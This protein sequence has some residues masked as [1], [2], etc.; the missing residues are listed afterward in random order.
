VWAVTYSL[1]GYVFGQYW[2][3]LLAVAKSIGYGIIAI[4]ALV[5]LAYVLRRRWSRNS[6]Q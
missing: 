4:V 6:P 2:D 5:L 3:E 1:V